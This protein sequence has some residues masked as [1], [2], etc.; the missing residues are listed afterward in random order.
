MEGRRILDLVID[1]TVNDCL[2][3]IVKSRILDV[4]VQIG[5]RKSLCSCQ[6]GFFVVHNIMRRAHFGE[7]WRQWIYFYTSM[8]LFLQIRFSTLINGEPS[9]FFGSSRGLCLGNLLSPL[10]FV[11]VMKELTKL[12]KR[13]KK[14]ASWKVFQASNSS[15]GEKITFCSPMIPSSFL[16]HKPN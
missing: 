1:L 5:F 14:R 10:L 7:K 9:G 6:L 2:N 12:I 11:L 16:S 15:R 8:D 3:S 4:F 13:T